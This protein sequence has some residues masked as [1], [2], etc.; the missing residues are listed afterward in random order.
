MT[1]YDEWT[2]KQIQARAKKLAAEAIDIWT[3]PEEFNSRSINLGDTFNLD[4]D[5]GALKGTRPATLSIGDKEIKMPHWNHL[6]REIVRQLYA[7]DKDTFRQATA[8]RKNLFTTEPTYFKLD[9][10]FYMEVGF[11]TEDCLRIAKS[12][13]ESFD[14]IGDT[15]FKED[16]SFRL[17]R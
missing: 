8:V 16:I 10:N 2:S 6:L 14:R 15:N 1:K 12:L 17:R 5:F 7:L 9:E 11:S 3:L 4:S 13:V